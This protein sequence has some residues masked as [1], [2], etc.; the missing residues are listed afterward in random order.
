MLDSTVELIAQATSNFHLIFC[1]CNIIIVF[2]L[3]DRSKSD[4]HPIPSSID[5][6]HIDVY[7]N[8]ITNDYKHY[9][10]VI[11]D[12]HTTKEDD[13]D[14]E[15]EAKHDHEHERAFEINLNPTTV[16]IDNENH[17]EVVEDDYTKERLFTE[18]VKQKEEDEVLHHHELKTRIEIDD[19]NHAEVVVDDHKKERSSTEAVE[20]KEE[21]EVLHDYELKTRIEEFI[22]KIHKEW[23]AERLRTAAM[24]HHCIRVEIS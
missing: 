10:K 21:D 4:S 19:K 5:V 14:S 18:A 17:A 2:L 7:P 13:E 3:I 12:D 16:K 1:F 20:H 11:E 15:M 22:N 24:Q 6:L 8:A 23:K 9:P